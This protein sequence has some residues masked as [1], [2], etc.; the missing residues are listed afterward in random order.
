MKQPEAP[1]QDQD[2]D[3]TVEAKAWLARLDAVRRS[4]GPLP[5][6]SS[7]DYLRADR[8]RDDDR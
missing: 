6:P 8:A 1:P 5:G 3:R 7:L 2:I 4:I